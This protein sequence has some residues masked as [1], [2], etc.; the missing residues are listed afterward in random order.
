[1]WNSTSMFMVPGARAGG[2]AP[3]RGWVDASARPPSARPGSPRE[4]RAS[5]RRRRGQPHGRGSRRL[6]RARATGHRSSGDGQQGSL[7]SFKFLPSFGP[8]EMA[9]GVRHFRPLA[10]GRRG[11]APGGLR[12]GPC[13]GGE[14]RGAAPG[15]RVTALLPTPSVSRCHSLDAIKSARGFALP[16]LD[17]PLPPNVNPGGPRAG[18]LQSDSRRGS[19][20]L[21]S[22]GAVT[23]TG[24]LRSQPQTCASTPV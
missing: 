19:S 18:E 12:R 8:P 9:L 24:L 4:A 6:G 20:W 14:R 17:D 16:M 2:G 11:G 10:R 15:P 1:M 21:Q 3:D 7:C 5:H 22:A 23:P 13:T